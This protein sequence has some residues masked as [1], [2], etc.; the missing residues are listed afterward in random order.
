MRNIHLHLYP[1]ETEGIIRGK[2]CIV[3]S[4]GVINLICLS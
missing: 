1:R 3:S 4:D 2:K